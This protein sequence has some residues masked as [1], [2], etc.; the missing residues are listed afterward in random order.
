[1]I[2]AHPEPRDG[3]RVWQIRALYNPIFTQRKATTMIT[4]LFALPA[5]TVEE[6]FVELLSRP[7][8]KIERIVSM[9]QASPPGFWCEQ[10]ESEWVVVLAGE[11]Q[12][13]FEDEPEPRRLTPGDFIDIPS[14]RRHRV[15][16]THPG[17]PTVWLAI[18]YG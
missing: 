15:Q 11:A 9:G 1:M 2:R 10:E 18:H 5:D 3:R 13:R 14:H 4:N 8:L 6:Q 12:L 16:W 7:G 17:Q